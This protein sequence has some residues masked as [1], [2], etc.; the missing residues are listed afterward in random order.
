MAEPLVRVHALASR[1]DDRLSVVSELCPAEQAVPDGYAP[2]LPDAV[3]P[4]GEWRVPSPDEL[5]SLTG[6]TG[7]HGD[8]DV[9]V[10]SVPRLASVLADH[11]GRR[12]DF[13]FLHKAVRDVKFVRAIDSCIDD[14]IPYC[15]SPDGLECQGAWVSPGGMRLVTHNMN[16]AP[17]RRIGLHVDNWDDLPPP[18]RARGRRRLCVNLGL[19]PRYLLFLPTPLSALVASGKFPRDIPESVSPAILVRA[20]LGKNLKQLAARVRIDPGEAYVM[21][22]DD[23]IH[24]GASD[25]PGAPDIALHFLGHF[26]IAA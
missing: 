22:A 4:R 20:Y 10:V 1:I 5:S 2:F 11:L 24:D 26:G 8:S 15:V 9:L 21:N 7:A 3:A 13:A 14:L 18:D 6:V 25:A 19:K 23:V 17:P 12:E 16:L